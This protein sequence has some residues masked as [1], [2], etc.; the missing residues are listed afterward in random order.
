MVNHYCTASEVKAAVNF[1]AV[2]SPLTDAQITEMIGYAEEEIENIY[3][4][5]FGNICYSGT[6]SAGN[7]TT[8][9]VATTPWTANEYIDYV[10]WVHT[11]TNAGEYRLITSNTDN[12]LT[13]SPAFS[14][15][16]DA[17]SQFRI[18]KL[19]YK[20][21][22]LDG[23]G[24]DY[25]FLPYQPLISL[26]GLTIDSTSVTPS[27]VYKTYE[28]GKL[29]LGTSDCEVKYFSNSTPQLVSVQ[30]VYGVYPMPQII[31]RL[32]IV[33]AGIRAL[34][35]Q[36]AGTYDDF[37]NVSLPGGLTASK[38][39]PYTNIRE[40]VAGLQGEARGI[41]YGSQTTG[42]IGGDFRTVPSYRPFSL[43]G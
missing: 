1:P 14:A 43:F 8:I 38:G 9:T 31:K 30:Y 15:A 10:V 22:T 28:S 37:T 11:G 33:M 7:T 35:A 20:D 25:M 23:T 2:G 41:I 17:T 19:G 24:T 27:Y 16:I 3:K 32:C 29:V 18:V 21:Q 13:V 4:T 42:Q 6:A 40:A 39:E 34:V 5:K 12:D 36:I 26:V